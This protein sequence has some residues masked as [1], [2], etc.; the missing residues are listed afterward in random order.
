MVAALHPVLPEA[1][2]EDLTQIV[3][4]SAALNKLRNVNL[5]FRVPDELKSLIPQ[6]APLLDSPRKNTKLKPWLRADA[7][8]CYWRARTLGARKPVE[9]SLRWKRRSTKPTT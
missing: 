8:N 4:S 3:R 7:T 5:Q 6:V 1:T 9:P 2:A